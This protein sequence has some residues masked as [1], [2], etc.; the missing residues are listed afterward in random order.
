M[1]QKKLV[2]GTGY[3]CDRLDHAASGSFGLGKE[4][5]SQCKDKE[6]PSKSGKIDMLRRAREG[7]G[8][9]Y[10]GLQGTIRLTGVVIHRQRTW[11]LSLSLQNLPEAKL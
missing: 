5:N 8:L 2:P 6:Y 9:V 4:S 3:C 11:L 7:G 1:K 10:K